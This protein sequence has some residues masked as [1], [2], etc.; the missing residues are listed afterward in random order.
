MRFTWVCRRP[1][2][3][4][5]TTS[6]LRASRGRDAVEDHRP[7]VAAA[8]VRAPPRSP[9]AGPTR[10]SCS[11]AAA[12]KVSPAT[13]SGSLPSSFRC[14]AILP[15]VVVLPVPLTPT[16]RITAG[17]WATSMRVSAWQKCSAVTSRSLVSRAR[18]SP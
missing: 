3:S 2:V 9:R 15:M 16:M 6:A 4:M 14:Q 5:I 11:T 13:R 17:A 18:P 1:A 10:I 8:L 12:R 7:R